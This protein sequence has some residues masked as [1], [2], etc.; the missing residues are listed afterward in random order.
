MCPLLMA[1]VPRLEI[2][3]Y[4]QTRKLNRH[5]HVC[6]NPLLPAPDYGCTMTTC[7]KCDHVSRLLVSL[8]ITGKGQKGNCCLSSQKNKPGR[9]L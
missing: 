9:G 4:I 1:P 5:K 3:D 8:P 2:S 6:I 7:T